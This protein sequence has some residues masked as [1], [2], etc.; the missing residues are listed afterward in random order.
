MSRLGL[1]LSLIPLS[2][3]GARFFFRTRMS[4]MSSG[5]GLF[6]T[7][8]KAIVFHWQSKMALKIVS[9]QTMSELVCESMYNR[10]RMLHAFVRSLGLTGSALIETVRGSPMH[11]PA[12]SRWHSHLAFSF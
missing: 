12:L 6:R 8:D 3:K 7:K 10:N 11:G 5:Y 9:G 2:V 4:L 1:R